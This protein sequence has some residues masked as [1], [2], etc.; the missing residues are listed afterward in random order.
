MSV[1]VIQFSGTKDALLICANTLMASMQEK[2]PT[3]RIRRSIDIGD[4]GEYTDG[5]GSVEFIDVVVDVGEAP[6]A[7][8][9]EW[10]SGVHRTIGSPT[11]YEIK[12]REKKFLAF[13]WDKAE[14]WMRFLPDG[15]VLFRVVNHP[16]V[17]PRPF[18]RP[19]IQDTKDNIRTIIGKSVT[20]DI[21]TYLK[22]SFSVK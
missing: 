22:E 18:V 10:G 11:K 19:A 14:S 1:P 15:R 8:A 6:E 20:I 4:S 5:N 7:P 13:K 21:M 16:G 2:A 17:A 3:K 12:P 9:Y